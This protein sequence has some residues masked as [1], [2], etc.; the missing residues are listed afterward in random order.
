MWFK[1]LKL[2]SITQS[3]DWNE[4]DLEKQL[5]AFAFRPCSSQE[6]SSMGFASPLQQG[7]SLIH[8]AQGRIWICLKKQERLLPAVVVNAELAE[9]VAQIEAET[10]SP[11]GKK[12]QQDL[13]Q[14]IIHRLLPQAFTKNSFTHGFVSLQ[15]NLVVVDASADGK[16]EAFLAMLRKAMTSLPVVPLARKSIQADLTS[17]VKDGSSPAAIQLL[18]EAE[19]RGQGEQDSIVRVKNQD[20]GEDEIIQHIDAGKFVHKLAVEWDESLSAMIEEDLSI[21]RLKFT[22]VVKEQNDDIA[23]EDKLARLDADFA[24]MSGEIVRFAQW[25]KTTFELDQD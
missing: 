3:L 15:D 2:F 20:L 21:K 14:E 16:A 7:D 17:W 10:G 24:L 23:K 13:K 1:N 5:G 25:L 8:S 22:D 6:L 19:F 4:T 11:V 9:K 18:E 12:A